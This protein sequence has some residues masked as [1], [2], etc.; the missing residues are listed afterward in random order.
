MRHQALE[1]RGMTTT[2]A[3]MLTPRQRLAAYRGIARVQA[4]TQLVYRADFLF[5][6]LGLLLQIYLLRLVWEAVYP[7]SGVA[8][9][10]GGHP[11]ALAT[12]IAY[13]TFAAVQNWLLTSGDVRF[14]SQR[15]R[16][17]TVAVDLARP[18]PF[19]TQMV[20][21]QA[22]SVAAQ[23]PFA[24]VALP[25]AV[26]AGG[27]Q[28]PASTLDAVAYAV[29]LVPALLISLLI[30]TLVSMAAFWTTET[31]GIFV[32]Y[33]FVQQF[34]AGS[35]MPLWFMP[36]WL[37]LL[38][39]WLPF[40]ATTYAPLTIYLGQAGAAE[41]IGLQLAWCAVLMCALRIVWARALHRVVV[42]GG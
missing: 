12:Q 25:F 36:G 4:R 21:A 14:I 31:S 38:S 16:E 18:V 1:I 19:T 26:L 33:R 17:G 34:L 15:V 8:A 22:G 3:P 41:T 11:I 9:G 28:A 40:Q 5:R 42:Q 39:Q 35:L 29:S 6:L 7:A 20:W 37:R 23:A 32:I 13:V 30:T 27:A 10:S 2:L 24:V